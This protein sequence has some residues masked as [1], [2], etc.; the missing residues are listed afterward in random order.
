MGLVLAVEREFDLGRG[1]SRRREGLAG[2]KPRLSLRRIWFKN[3]ILFSYKKKK[4][5]WFPM[6][7]HTCKWH[8][9]Q[10]FFAPLSQSTT[11]YTTQ[12]KVLEQSMR[13]F[14]SVCIHWVYALSSSS[15]NRTVK[16]EGICLMIQCKSLVAVVTM[17]KYKHYTGNYSLYPKARPCRHPSRT[18]FSKWLLIEPLFGPNSDHSSKAIG[19]FAHL[20]EE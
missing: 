7:T 12:F 4:A 15:T 20:Q 16:A 9:S 19:F 13:R 8:S 6:Y 17:L 10:P 1:L 3:Q 11:K 5:H 14:G 2:V 18:D